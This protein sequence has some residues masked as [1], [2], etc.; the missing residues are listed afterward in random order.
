MLIGK[1]KQ[2]N[3]HCHSVL[4]SSTSIYPHNPGWHLCE[5][6]CPSSVWL[7]PWSFSSFDI[8]LA[9]FSSAWSSVL[10]ATPILEVVGESQPVWFGMLIATH[11]LQ[12]CWRGVAG[13]KGTP[14]ISSG[15][16]R[17]LHSGCSLKPKLKWKWQAF[18]GWTCQV[19]FIWK[20]CIVDFWQPHS[21]FSPRAS[22]HKPLNFQ[23]AYFWIATGVFHGQ[24]LC[25]V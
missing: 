4:A 3:F 23:N 15:L 9:H 13:L 8:Q 22:L 17:R 6:R 24:F 18:W 2:Q 16:N 14:A 11:S 20:I 7:Y 12:L 5:C 19:S 1:K 21:G 25:S 10:W